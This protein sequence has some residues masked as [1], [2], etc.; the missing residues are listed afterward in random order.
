MGQK[1][2]M[3]TP[4]ACEYSKALEADF[5]A[6]GTTGGGVGVENWGVLNMGLDRTPPVSFAGVL[7]SDILRG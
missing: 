7:D 3:Q 1:M 2:G 5:Q 6:N 4:P